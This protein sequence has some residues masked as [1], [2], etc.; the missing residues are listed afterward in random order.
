MTRASQPR[1]G[2]APP[3]HVR[4]LGRV[5]YETA[6]ELQESAL[7]AKIAGDP[8]DD[9]ILLEHPPVYTLGRG[10]SAADLQAAPA[11]RDVPVHRVGRGGGATFHG[12]GQLVSY[13][14]VCL[15]PS[16]RDVH[17]YIRA[18]ERVLV[19]TCAKMGVN[20]QAAAGQ[21]GVWV[22]E[23]KIGSIGIGVRRG[24][25]FHGT[26]L[27]VAGDLS[28]FAPI[29]VCRSPGLRVTSVEAEL[30]WAPPIERVA[31]FYAETF[32]AALG[33]PPDA[34]RITEW[35]A[36]VNPWRDLDAPVRGRHSRD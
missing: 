30:G 32:A 27:N 22:G 6:L 12:P 17:R 14:I 8:A 34:I 13:P 31:V 15:R 16:G 7:A 26:A 33:Y 9:L 36:P 23:R 21:T 24:V 25:A 20:A 19:G 28:L 1:A 5:A 4:Y 10:A 18:L 29:V 2:H 11:G 35:N 3:L